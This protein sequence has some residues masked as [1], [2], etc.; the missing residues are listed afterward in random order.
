MAGLRPGMAPHA[1]PRP[2]KQRFKLPLK[3]ADSYL[4]MLV[5]SS[6]LRGLCWFG[7]LLFAFAVI[8]AVRRVVTDQLPPLLVLKLIVYQLPRIL[9][10]TLPMSALYGTVQTFSDLSTRGELTALGVGGMSLPRMV[11]APLAWGV[12]LAILAFWL[13]EAVV[14]KAERRNSQVVARTLLQT[15]GL[16]QYFLLVDH[17]ENNR[18]QRVIQADAFD[19]KTRTLLSPSI[20]IYNENKEVALDI[21]AERANWDIGRG[22]WIF[23]N[24]TTK[25]TPSAKSQDLPLPSVSRFTQLDID[26]LPDPKILKV[27]TATINEQLEKRN[28]EMLSISDLKAYR[29]KQPALLAPST[30][31]KIREKI[32]ARMRSLTFGIHDKI[33][34]PLICIAVILIAAP[35]GVRPQR[36]GGGFAMGLSLAALLVYYIVWSWVSQ[37]GKSGIGNPFILAYMPLS[38]TLAIGVV[39]MRLKSK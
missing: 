15:Q 5:I 1:V 29:D 27:S 21:R 17:T 36:S 14:P 34:T 28:Y 6:T 9:L 8:T 30:Y 31:P 37:I 35:L 7:G 38:L 11:R 19:V 32:E 2:W 33:A 16:Q 39:L 13:Q 10:F 25:V 26:V 20:Q 12:L 24:G 18:L 23:Y 3:I 22:K 4:L